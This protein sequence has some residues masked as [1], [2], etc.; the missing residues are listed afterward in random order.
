MEFEKRVELLEKK[1]NDIQN[2]LS[3]LQTNIGFLNPAALIQFKGKVLQALEHLDKAVDEL[4]VSVKGLKDSVGKFKTDIKVEV[5]KV[6]VKNSLIWG[7]V[8]AIVTSGLV[9][10]LINKVLG[11]G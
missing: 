8:S 7:I 10:L 2:K 6:A 4:G 9:Y 1:V 5:S 3:E 11:G